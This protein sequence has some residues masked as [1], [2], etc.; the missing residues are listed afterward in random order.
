MQ[1]WAVLPF[2]LVDNK[3]T[4]SASPATCSNTVQFDSFWCVPFHTLLLMFESLITLH[5]ADVSTKI[6]AIGHTYGCI[7]AHK[8]EKV[9]PV[10]QDRNTGS[11][12]ISTEDDPFCFWLPTPSR[13]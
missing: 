5:R 9:H 3:T 4:L 8:E 11:S 10:M 2:L 1:F 6:P 13:F 12:K 7:C